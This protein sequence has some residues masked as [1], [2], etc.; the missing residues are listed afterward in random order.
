M[1]ED[2]VPPNSNNAEQKTA[3]AA[4][5]MPYLGGGVRRR[6]RGR[7]GNENCSHFSEANKR[8]AI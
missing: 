6:G 8:D 2:K 3:T 4:A 1:I 5:E 7:N